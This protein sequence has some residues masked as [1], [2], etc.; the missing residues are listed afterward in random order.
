[1]HTDAADRRRI[2]VATIV[3]VVALPALWL[4]GRDD[5]GGPNTPIAVVGAAGALEAAGDTGTGALAA[6]ESAV[7]EPATTP[8][9]TVPVDEPAGDPFASADPV[10]LAGPSTPEAPPPSIVYA[11]PGSTR[12]ATG[13][14]TFK[15]WDPAWG[16]LA[17]QCSVAPA[18]ARLTI[19][20][21]NNGRSTTCTNVLTR[22]TGTGSVLVLDT[23]AFLQLANLVEAPLPVHISW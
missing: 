15:R 20:N 1:M 12:Q 3:T 19:T 8:P 21:L 2:A 14:A 4:S 7:T 6:N 16:A 18:N 23:D 11:D 22:P 9:A 10:F 5:A 17:C 13:T